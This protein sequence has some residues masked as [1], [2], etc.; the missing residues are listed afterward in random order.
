MTAV[1]EL[2]FANQSRGLIELFS[3]GNLHLF[4]KGGE[5]DECNN[6]AIVGIWMKIGRC[7]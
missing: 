2:H 5:K 3:S 6:V 4:V 1:V 7:H